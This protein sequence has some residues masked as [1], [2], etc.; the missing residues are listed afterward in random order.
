MICSISVILTT[1]LQKRYKKIET[2]LF[3]Y[4]F[5]IFLKPWPKIFYDGTMN[6]F[7]TVITKIKIILFQVQHTT[8][9]DKDV[10]G[11]LG[12]SP[13]T[14]ASMKRRNSMPYRHILDFCINHHINANTLLFQKAVNNTSRPATIKYYSHI[15]A[16]A[17]S[18]KKIIDKKHLNL[19]VE[20]L[21]QFFIFRLTQNST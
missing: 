16:E 12:L 3:L 13:S 2:A 15:N 7:E 9:H 21:L 14:F 8:V 1:L 6:N 4:T 10:A 20:D 11:A 5:A 18:T 17:S 19:A